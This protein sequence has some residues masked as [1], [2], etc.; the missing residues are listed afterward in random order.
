MGLQG[1]CRLL[2]GRPPDKPPLGQSLLRH[3]KPLAVERQD[4]NRRGPPAAKN[5]QAPGER[6]GTQFFSA[7]LRQSIDTL[8]F[9]RCTAKTQLCV[10]HRYAEFL[11]WQMT[12]TQSYF[13]EKD[14]VL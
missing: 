9:L 13:G 2:A 1:S 8:P 14:I 12:N 11:P 5:E 10:V 3:P 4:F 7:Q 6:V